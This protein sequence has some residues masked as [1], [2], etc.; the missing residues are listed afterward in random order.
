MTKTTLV[1]RD[2]RRLSNPRQQTASARSSEGAVHRRDLLDENQD[3]PNDQ[4]NCDALG[5]NWVGLTFD[6]VRSTSTESSCDAN[7][8][9]VENGKS[10]PEPSECSEDD[11]GEGVADDLEGLVAASQRQ[12]I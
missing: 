3:T 11:E 5:K 8:R 7:S 10:N 9:V 6:C 4:V 1:R 2:P 12:R